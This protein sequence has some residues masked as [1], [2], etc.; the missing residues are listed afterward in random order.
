H[1]V[2]DRLES[3]VW[4]GK[5]R[6]TNL[7]TRFMG[8]PDDAY[9]RECARIVLLGAVTRIFEPGHKFDFV[10]ILEGSQG[11]GKSQF[12]RTLSLGWYNELTGDPSDTKAMVETMQGSWILEMGELSAMGRVAVNDM[13]AFVTRPVDK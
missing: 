4:D 2:R 8:S 12:I 7:F 3:F 6:M 1:P 5:P 13:K 10:V 11:K 9:H